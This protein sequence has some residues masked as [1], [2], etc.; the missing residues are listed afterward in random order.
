[1]RLNL[2]SS[3]P[4]LG[5]FV[6]LSFVINSEIAVGQ[7]RFNESVRPILSDKCFFCHGPDAANRQADLRLDDRDDAITKG[8]ITPGNLDESEILSRI[9]SEDPDLQMPPPTSKLPK[10]TKDEV[11]I[12]EQWIREGAPYQKHW[13][14]ESLDWDRLSPYIRKNLSRSNSAPDSP[15]VDSPIDSFVKK[16]LNARGLSLQPVADRQVL[17]RR[18]AFDIT[19]LPP[20]P[21]LLNEYLKASDEPTAYSAYLDKLLASPHYGEKM[22]VDWLDISRYSDSFG[23]QVDRERAMWQWRDWVI[24]SF[25]E[26]KPFDQFIVEQIAGDMLPNPSKDQILATAF[27]RLHQQE[28]EGGSVEEEYRVEYVADRVQ[29]YATAFLGLTFEC[30]RCHD[31]KFDPITQKEYYGLFAMFQNIDEAG[32]YSYFTDSPPTPALSLSNVDQDKVLSELSEQVKKASAELISHESSLLASPE[33]FS[34]ESFLQLITSSRAPVARFDFDSLEDR[35]LKNSVSADKPATVDGENKLVEGRT[36]MA[37]EFTGDDAV[38][39]PLGN[40]QREEPF[41]ISLWLKTPDVKERAVVFHRSRAWTDAASRGYELLIEDGKLKWSLI[42]FWPGNAISIKTTANVPVNQ[43]THVAVTY[44]GSS[45]AK[46]LQI[47]VNGV[48]AETAI[49]KDKLT[50]TIAGGGYDNIDLGERFRDKG[51][52]NGLVDDFQVFPFALAPWEVLQQFDPESAK[53]W[54]QKATTDKEIY[55][56]WIAPIY[57]S[58]NEQSIKLAADLKVA[59]KKWHDYQ[60]SFSEIMVMQELATPK[61]AYVLIRGEYNQRAEPVSA[62]TPRVLPPLAEG[63]PNN[64]LGLA[65]WTVSRDHPLTARVTINRIWQSIFGIGLVKTSEDFGSQGS[66]PLYQ[67]VLDALSANF[68]ESGWNTKDL[69]KTILMSDVYRQRSISDNLQIMTDDPE[70]EL[71]A[72]GPRIRLSAEM[73]RDNMLASAGL[74]DLSLG[75]P[76]VNPYELSESFKPAGPSGGNGVYRRSLYTNWRRT[77]PPPAMIAFDAPRRAVCTPKRERTESA[78]QSLILLNG[79]QYVEAARALAA[80]AY[81]LNPG[82]EQK[83]IEAMFLAC[84]GRAPQNRE[85]EICQ[86]L[87]SEQREIFKASPEKAKEFLSVGR[88]KID[89]VIPDEVFAALTVLSQTLFNHDSCIMKR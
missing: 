57:A 71:L 2:S 82:D 4:I 81:M 83:Q 46:G 64:R 58:L 67:N 45:Q 14:F 78:L 80:K 12:L 40:F 62:M 5:G 29:T 26:N 55:K 75:G 27:N 38:K 66:M 42:H 10:L 76:P 77:G 53:T 23:F 48:M 70:N 21:E 59:R 65:H 54:L 9:H 7:I 56:Q 17:A 24:R 79:I 6:L 31:H 47:F 36:G 20:S 28:S 11:A 74:I 22:A 51:F 34:V 68:I 8:A 89:A 39:T 13:A 3:F 32:L 18:A 86:K 84:L 73:I 60:D 19:G 41:S 85:L 49:E 72:R 61:P 69:M 35:K 37:L 30:A 63:S 25:N 52:K 16:E 50:K 88:H 43:W 15:V 33:N 44:D 87:L 1:M